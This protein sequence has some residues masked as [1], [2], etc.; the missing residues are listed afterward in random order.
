MEEIYNCIIHKHSLAFGIGTVT[1]LLTIFLVSRHVIGFILSL[2]LLLAGLGATYG[3]EHQDVVQSYFS[4]F[5][6][7][8][9]PKQAKTTKEA[10][11]QKESTEP[12]D[13]TIEQRPQDKQIDS[14]QGKAQPKAPEENLRGQTERQRQ[15]SQRFINT[16]T[17]EP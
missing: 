17:P 11:P 4:R 14:S 6:N 5:I 9:S 13:R 12:S 10:P 2:L 7:I 8:F 16:H 3:I 1:L 15:R